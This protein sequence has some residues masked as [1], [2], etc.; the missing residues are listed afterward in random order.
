MKK[1]ILISTVMFLLG[2]CN[3][4]GVVQYTMTDIG[5]GTLEGTTPTGYDINNNGQI[6]GDADTR[7]G[8]AFLY[9]NGVIQYLGTLGGT[10]N[11]AYSINDNG[12]IVGSSS[13]SGDMESHGFLCSG[14]GPLQDLGDYLLCGINNSGQIVGDYSRS[15]FAN[16]AFLYSSGNMKE[17]GSLNGTND[18]GLPDSDAICINNNGQ[19][20]GYSYA[21]NNHYIH[22]FRYSGNGPMQDIGTLGGKNSDAWGINDSGQV[23]GWS[24]TSDGDGLQICHAFLYSDH[25]PMQDIGTLGGERSLAVDINNNGQ[26]VGLA[27][28]SDNDWHAYLYSENGPMQDLNDLIDHSSGWTLEESSAINDK[29]QIV[30]SGINSSGQTHIFLLT[31]IPEPSTVALLCVGVANFLLV[32]RKRST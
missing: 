8:R 16:H 25:G 6:V 7:N 18:D 30:C 5:L 3:A 31:P 9:S 17:I 11:A 4:F 27:M 22:A 29:G 2:V 15:D 32:R 23:V 14:N 20:A 21:N 28:T 1:I 12:L 24:D 10:G 13:L 26:V 19:I